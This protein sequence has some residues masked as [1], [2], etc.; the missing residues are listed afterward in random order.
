MEGYK[1]YNV[2]PALFTFIEDL[3]N[4]Y[5]RLNR[6]RFWG[7]GLSQDKKEAYSTLYTAVKE[8]S[9]AMAPFS[10]FLS[11]YIYQELKKFGQLDL[12]GSVHHCSY[13]L[14]NEDFIDSTLE[15][16][17]GRMQQIILLGRQKRN[18]TNIKVKTP[19]SKLTIIHKDQD[20][21]KEI[22]KLEGYIK[23]ELNVK[24]L[25]YSENELE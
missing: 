2:V 22:S 23:A 17:M 24:E 14:P 5:I 11:E 4:W 21:L 12:I 20:L 19:L 6:S 16:A 15:D 1:L 18:K 25:L 9:V 13:P 3:T 10:P 8:L 7:E